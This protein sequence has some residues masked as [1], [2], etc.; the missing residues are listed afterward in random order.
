MKGKV[1]GSFVVPVWSNYIHKLLFFMGAESTS[2]IRNHLTYWA[3][4]AGCGSR[5]TTVSLFGGMS[6]ASVAWFCYYANLLSPVILS[7]QRSPIFFFLPSPCGISY[8]IICFVPLFYPYHWWHTHH[9]AKMDSSKEDPG[10]WIGY[11][12]WCLLS[13][14]DL[15]WILPVGGSLLVPRCLP[16]PPVVR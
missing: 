1:E 16:G 7:L 14:F 12:D 10:R 2:C 4:W 3:H 11:M 5:I 15:S 8:L 6:C 9:S 13:P